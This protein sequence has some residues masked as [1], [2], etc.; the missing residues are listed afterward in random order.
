MTVRRRLAVLS[1]A[2]FALLAVGAPRLAHAGDV[3]EARRAARAAV[4]DR[5]A[6]LEARFR[7]FLDERKS[8]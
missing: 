3:E 5:L 6:D 8:P 1:P 2:L 7:R 4:V